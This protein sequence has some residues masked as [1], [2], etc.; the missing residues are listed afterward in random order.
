MLLLIGFPESEVKKIK[1]E[2]GEEIYAV[3]DELRDVKLKEIIKMIKK[4]EEKDYGRLGEQRIVLMHN[5]PKENIPKIMKKI[6]EAVPFHIIFATTTPTSLDWS[7]D[8]LIHELI[9]EDLYF[10][11]RG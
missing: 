5:I 9:E 6:K 1:E 8:E 3:D 10:S 7:L 2:M 4:R 11:K